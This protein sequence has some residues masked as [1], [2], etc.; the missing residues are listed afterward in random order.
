MRRKMPGESH[1]DTMTSMSNL[2]E[3]LENIDNYSKAG[4]LNLQVLAMRETI[5]GPD[6]LH[7][8]TSFNNLAQVLTTLGRYWEAEPI[9][10]RA[11][12]G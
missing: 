1:I 8:L 5:L 2:A 3:V 10:R 6:H 12:E 7:T 9:A 11:S 4:E